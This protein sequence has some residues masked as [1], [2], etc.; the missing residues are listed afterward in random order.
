M[1][2]GPASPSAL[3]NREL[4]LHILGFFEVPS[5]PLSVAHYS[6]YVFEQEISPSIFASLRRDELKSFKRKPHSEREWI[7]AALDI[8][9]FQ[10]VPR[11]VASSR[12]PLEHRLIGENTRRVN[13]LRV[14]LKL[15]ELARQDLAPSRQGQ[16]LQMLLTK[17]CYDAYPNFEEYPFEVIE[18][19]ARDELKEL[20]PDDLRDRTL[21]A[22][23]AKD[24]PALV[25]FWGV[26]DHSDP[27]AA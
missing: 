9:S 22:A 8:K 3:K 19:R 5:S 27:E 20:E 11:L 10:K 25:R 4:I 6:K 24:L 15:A 18:K 12:W 16:R 23:R 26:P 2:D 17:Y 13:E 1:T 14:L 7:V 21:A